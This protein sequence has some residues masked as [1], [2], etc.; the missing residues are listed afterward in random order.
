MAPQRA[1]RAFF[2]GN[3]R[4]GVVLEMIHRIEMSHLIDVLVGYATEGFPQ[5][6]GSLGP[7]RVGVGIVALPSDVID[8]DEVSEEEFSEWRSKYFEV[9][10]QEL[11]DQLVRVEQFRSRLLQQMARYDVLISPVNPGPA[12]KLPPPGDNPFPDGS[13]TEL[14]DVTGWPAGVVRAGTSGSGLPIGVQVI[15]NP[16]R[17]DVVLAVMALVEAGLPEFPLPAIALD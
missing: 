17:E 3:V 13:Y 8:P 5:T 16:W 9:S 15:A 1:N 11:N 12:P 4:E 2:A 6:L 7:G 14:F 10:A